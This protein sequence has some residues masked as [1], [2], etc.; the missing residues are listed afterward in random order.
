[1]TE[2]TAVEKQKDDA[3]TEKL[4]AVAG[5]SIE[6][7]AQAFALMHASKQAKIIRTAMAGI[8]SM[9]WGASLT[10]EMRSAVARYALENGT[11]PVRHWEVLGGNLYD[12]AELW[13]D[14]VAAQDDF[15]GFKFKYLH[16]DD[17]LTEEQ[18]LERRALR[19]E[20]GVPEDVPGACLITI[21]RTGRLPVEGVNWVGSRGKKRDPVGDAEPTKTAKTRAFRKAAK[22]AYPLW[23]RRKT[24]KDPEG[25]IELGTLSRGE[26]EERLENHRQET[27]QVE[28][29]V[30]HQLAPG[31]ALSGGSKATYPP[32]QVEE[33]PYAPP[34]TD[35]EITQHDVPEDAA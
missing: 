3:Q 21:F 27:K 24:Q 34:L 20:H 33:D 10:L 4:L 32:V 12:K 16:D 30:T 29:P 31:V 22:M 15:E 6:L 26:I 19:A 18:R 25:G 1:M 7:R 14:L 35:E 8:A 13:M 2:A 17:R 11:D 23:F 5:E 28:S 9:S